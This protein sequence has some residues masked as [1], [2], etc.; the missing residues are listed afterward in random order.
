[1]KK[2]LFAGIAAASFCGA[3]ALAADMPVKAPVYKAAPPVFSWTGCYI[4]AN[5]GYGWG[6]AT[7]VDLTSGTPTPIGEPHTSGALGGGQIGCDYQTGAWV[8]GVEGQFD[9][10]N[11]KGTVADPLNPTVVSIGHSVDWFATATARLGYAVDR[12]LWYVKGGALV[13]RAVNIATLIA[14]PSSQ[15]LSST[16]GGWTLGAGI[17]YAYAPNWSVKI[18]YDYLKPNSQHGVDTILG[19]TGNRFPSHENVVLVGLNYRFNG[20]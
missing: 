11:I 2:L 15:S 1:M 5:A 17:E 6:R 4:G 3:P 20:R 12:T 8:F 16:P 14:V 13:E 18:E 9:W 19:E 7:N 10:T